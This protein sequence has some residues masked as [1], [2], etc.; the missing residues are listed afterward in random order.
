MPK[1]LGPQ[2]DPGAQAR[3]LH[4]HTEYYL[5]VCL[6]I[7]DIIDPKDLLT[8]V[9]HAVAIHHNALLCVDASN[10]SEID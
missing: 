2:S 9:K 1:C 4:K 10:S 8:Y 7:S 5:Y 3:N 6:R